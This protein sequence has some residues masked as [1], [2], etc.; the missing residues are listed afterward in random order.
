MAIVVCSCKP[1]DQFDRGCAKSN[2][3]TFDKNLP[4]FSSP[5]LF[6]NIV[7]GE[8]VCREK[9]SIFS[10][11]KSHP[12]TVAPAGSNRSRCGGNETTEAFDAKGR[13]SDSASRQA[14]TYVNAEQASKSQMWEPTQLVRGE[15]RCR[16][17][18]GSDPIPPAVPPG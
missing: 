13:V 16:R 12:A 10:G 1:H 9:V 15:G 8:L 18:P 2:L 4:D 6:A 3:T 5:P 11:C 7:A 17:F 14:V